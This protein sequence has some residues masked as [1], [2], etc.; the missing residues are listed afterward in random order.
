M[1]VREPAERHICDRPSALGA[2]A[3]CM[4]SFYGNTGQRC[5]A[6]ANLVIVGE[7]LTAREGDAFYKKVVDA[8]VEAASSMRIGYGLDESVQ[9]GPLRNEGKKKRVLSYIEQGIKEGAR[10]TL[11]GRNPQ[12]VGDYPDTAFL[13]PAVFEDVTP[14]MVIAQ[15]EIFGP[16]AA[17]IKARPWTRSLR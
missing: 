4:T 14:D 17:I 7:G 5:L 13:G 1:T 15:E 2:S 11:N 6:N 10:L 12:I 3:P 16:V 8:F 9:M